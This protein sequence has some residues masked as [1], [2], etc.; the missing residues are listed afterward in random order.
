MKTN[1]E[2]LSMNK[3]TITYKNYVG[4]RKTGGGQPEQ[5]FGES[6]FLWL[7]VSIFY[8]WTLILTIYFVQMKG[9]VNKDGEVLDRYKIWI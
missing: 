6:K 4:D 7:M 3:A 9:T 2:R 1:K 5:Q 8:V